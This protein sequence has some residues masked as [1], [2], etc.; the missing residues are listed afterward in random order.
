MPRPMAKALNAEGLVEPSK[1]AASPMNTGL[2]NEVEQLLLRDRELDS[3]L[4]QLR[5][6]PVLT[7]L[8]T[9]QWA[10]PEQEKSWA[11][12]PDTARSASGRFERSS[13]GTLSPAAVSLPDLA[14][15]QQ[16]NARL[17]A[18]NEG[19]RRRLPEATDRPPAIQRPTVR[20]DDWR[21]DA[22]GFLEW[23]HA[24][25]LV[26]IRL[27]SLRHLEHA[28]STLP[29]GAIVRGAPPIDGS[30]ELYAVATASL[31]DDA[32]LIGEELPALLRTLADSGADA[33][34]IH[35]D[36]L[37][38]SLR[39]RVGG[40]SRLD[41]A[42]LFTF[43]RVRTVVL[44]V[45]RSPFGLGVPMAYMALAT[46]CQQIVAARD[47]DGRFE[48]LVRDGL[49]PQRFVDLPA[50]LATCHFEDRSEFEATIAMFERVV[51]GLRPIAVD[52]E[53]FKTLCETARLCWLKVWYLRALSRERAEAPAPFPRQQDVPLEGAVF[54]YPT[55]CKIFVASHAWESQYHPAPS[56][57]K[58]VR[59][60]EALE[61]LHADDDDVCFL[62]FMSL[63]QAAHAGMPVEY[64]AA[65]G[66]SSPLTQRTHEQASAAS[67]NRHWP[68]LSGPPSL[69]ASQRMPRFST[70][71]ERSVQVRPLGDVTLIRL[72]RMPRYR[73]VGSR[74]KGELPGRRLFMGPR[75]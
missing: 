18:E 57:R 27:G 37:A 4:Q 13:A 1:L 43:H 11:T 7:V 28:T 5:S 10:T 20:S 60:V 41:R 40:P 17:Q 54:G 36:A 16:E 68:S 49:E 46:F 62:D 39:V 6:F 29:E 24:N 59:L 33:D 73:V 25:E 71:A 70:V 31:A 45:G 66:A 53:G 58:L 47:V 75:E 51:Q 21:Y 61:E 22:A 35:W 34:L 74:P 30:A 42:R 64:F 8:G 2:H 69:P 50:T 9:H 44:A 12:T 56:G 67:E 38:R 72:P 32:P 3:E 19:L 23:S 48:Q 26:W 52:R 63:P 55:G 14:A 15:L 65:T